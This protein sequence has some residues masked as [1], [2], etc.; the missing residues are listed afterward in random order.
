MVFSHLWDFKWLQ[1]DNCTLDGDVQKL[2]ADIHRTLPFYVNFLGDKDFLHGKLTVNDFQ[3]FEQLEFF[4]D[5]FGR[6]NFKE[7]Y[8]SLVSFHEKIAAIPQIQNYISSDRFIKGPFF[9]RHAKINL[10]EE[11]E[12]PKPENEESYKVVLDRH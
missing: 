4:L 7:K 1:A 9:S 10:N 2:E 11:F 5:Y 3:L 8:P 12:K 6:E